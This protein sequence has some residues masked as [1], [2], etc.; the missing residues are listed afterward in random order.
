MLSVLDWE[1]RNSASDVTAAAA[2]ATATLL[3]LEDEVVK[4]SEAGRRRNLI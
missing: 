1:L 2:D 4:L 3:Q